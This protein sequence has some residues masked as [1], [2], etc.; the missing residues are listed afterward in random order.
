MHSRCHSPSNKSREIQCRI[1]IINAPSCIVE[2]IVLPYVP[3]PGLC[4]PHQLE[5]RGTCDTFCYCHRCDSRCYL[6]F[7]MGSRPWQ[8][9]RVHV[10]HIQSYTF[11]SSDK[12]VE[13]STLNGWHQTKI[14]GT[15]TPWITTFILLDKTVYLFITAFTYE[16]ATLS[17]YEKNAV[18]AAFPPYSDRIFKMRKCVSASGN[19]NHKETTG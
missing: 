5:D 18:Y 12:N 11:D 10:C 15:E 6:Q 17:S 3:L 16:K 2:K 1:H 13:K 4:Q 19:W 7:S 9:P 14:F 8:G